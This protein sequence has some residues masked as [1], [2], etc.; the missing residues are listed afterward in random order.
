MSEKRDVPR[1][2]LLPAAENSAD[3]RWPRVLVPFDR[4]EAL[5][6]RA[7]AKLA[8]VSE[9]TVRKWCGLY[10][11]GRRVAGGPWKVSRIALALFLDGNEIGLNSYLRGDR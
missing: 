1:L 5:S 8:G 11:I 7:A 9:G 6:L 2:R 4:A 3:D 10:F